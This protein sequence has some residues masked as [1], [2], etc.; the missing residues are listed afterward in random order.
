MRGNWRIRPQAD[1]RSQEEPFDQ[2][3]PVLL[4][5][6]GNL[7]L[8]LRAGFPQQVQRKSGKPEKAPRSKH[9]TNGFNGLR[10]R[11]TEGAG[12]RR[13]VSTAKCALRTMALGSATAV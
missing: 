7:L 2:P 3:R 5:K 11:K 10:I 9:R 8:Y 1:G 4:P 13:L 6:M 12:T